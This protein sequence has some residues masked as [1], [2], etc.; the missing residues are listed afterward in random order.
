MRVNKNGGEG[1]GKGRMLP[2]EAR[3]QISIIPEDWVTIT[4]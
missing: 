4:S 1:S 3:G 2:G